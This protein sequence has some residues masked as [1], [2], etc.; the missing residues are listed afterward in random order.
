MQPLTSR[1]RARTAM[2]LAQHA[3]VFELGQIASYCFN[4]DTETQ[5]QGIYTYFSLTGNEFGNLVSTMWLFQN[6]PQKMA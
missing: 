3:L 6:A 1:H 5:R 4:R 2:K